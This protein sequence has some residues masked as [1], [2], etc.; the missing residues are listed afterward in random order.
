MGDAILNTAKQFDLGTEPSLR[1]PLPVNIGVCTGPAY[2]SVVGTRAPRYVFFGEAVIGATALQ[3]RCLRRQVCIIAWS[4]CCRRWMRYASF[5][6][7]LDACTEDLIFFLP[8]SSPPQVDAPDNCILVC[9]RTFEALQHENDGKYS[10]SVAFGRPEK[11]MYIAPVGDF[12]NALEDSKSGSGTDN[13]AV[14]VT[15]GLDAELFQRRGSNCSASDGST[16]VRTMHLQ[17]LKQPSLVT[18]LQSAMDKFDKSQQGTSDVLE[19]LES[20]SN[21]LEVKIKELDKCRYIPPPTSL[22]QFFSWGTFLGS[23]RVHA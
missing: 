13:R 15:E 6:Y 11:Q 9:H 10:N 16:Y 23:S 2:A 19:E 7:R 22:P 12:Q 8:M 1:Y 14:S 3:V 20:C 5:V 4:L 21:D 18:A 17:I